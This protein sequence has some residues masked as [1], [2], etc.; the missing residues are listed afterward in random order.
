MKSKGFS[1]KRI[2]T[3]TVSSGVLAAMCTVGTA[4]LAQ[5]DDEADEIVV[6]GIRA[7]LADALDQKRNADILVE[8]IEAE[9]IGKLP[10]QNLA[11]VLENI[12]GVQ[13]NRDAGVGTGVQIRGT[14]SNRVEINGVST[15][16][17]GTNRTGISFEDLPASIISA[18]EV[19]KVPEAKTIEGSVGGTVNLRTI[20]PLGL[21]EPL[22]AFR[23]QGEFSDLSDSVNPR[24]SGT[25]GN[26]W[27]TSAGEFGLVV[28]GS[29]AEL[30]V[31]QFDPRFDRDRE[32]SPDPDRPSSEAF[33]FLRTQFLD[34]QITRNLFETLNFTGTAEW[35]P[36]DNLRFYFDATIND[37]QVQ[38][39]DARAFFSGIGSLGPVDA[40]TNTAFETVNL[41]T[42]DGPNGELDLGTVQAVLT[43][44]VGVGINPNN[45]IDTNLRTTSN[46]GSRVT[47]SRVFALGGEWSSDR[48]TVAA[49]GSLSTSDTVFPTLSVD[50]DF[51]NPNGPQPMVG[52]STDNGVP[53]EFDARDRT[54][55]FGIAQGL[56]ETP[57][58]EQ[59][60][61]PANYRL[62]QIVQGASTT[63]NSETAFRLDTNYDL[64][65]QVSFFTSVDAGY[66]YNLTEATNNVISDTLNLTSNGPATFF[67][68]TADLFA[69][70]VVAGPDNFDSA[71]GRA[72]F[73]RDYL[74]IDP[75]LA[76]SDPQ[77]VISGLNAAITQS[78]QIN[79]AS[80][81]LIGEPS[82]AQASFFDIDESTHALYFQANYDSVL[83]SLPV[84]GNVGLRW[85]STTQTTIGNNVVDGVAEP[86]ES[87]S[88]Y[89]AFLPRWSL[90]AEPKEDLLIR[91]GISRDLRRPNFDFLS[92]SVTFGTN[93]AATVDTG[94]PQ[95]EPE[96]V[97][98]YDISA[99]YYFA[100]TGILSLGFF[101]KRRTNLF[102]FV[103]DN[104][105]STISA[106]GQEERDITPPCEAGGIFNPN[107]NR[108]VF[109]SIEGEGICVPLLTRINADGVATQTGIEFQVQYDLAGFE[110]R[111]GWASGFGF[112][113]NFTYQDDGGSVD[114]FLD[115]SG[116]ANALNNVLGRTDTD[117]LT[118]TL[119]DDPVFQR[120]SLL[121]L[122]NLAYNATV[123]YDKYGVNFRARYTWRSDFLSDENPVSFD[124]PRVVDDRGQLNASLTYAINDNITVGIEGINLLREDRTEFCV[125]DEALLCEQGLTDRRITAG[126]SFRF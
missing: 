107:A 73:V 86:T 10:D 56:P 92:T 27:D 47:D 93:A 18:V 52:V 112:I 62:R 108:N 89:S 33:P 109:S 80:T 25:V 30:N 2:L 97:W 121:N 35:K 117:N 91:A 113:G 64:T 116:D 20:R 60:L 16:S 101:H 6:K 87:E 104:P 66:R 90:V 41:G 49:E 71:D 98:S 83:G 39:Q 21:S 126:V 115:G 9:D 28:S 68:P 13:I 102:T 99:E 14:D 4:A 44:V 88:S 19:I 34:Q 54:L 84:R 114:T 111:I 124:L 82:V 3:A 96:T 53:A 95:L 123:F 51:I 63:D 38:G 103:V 77:A 59:L 118:A 8:V 55:Q 67:R 94:N 24:F 43:G 42:L 120:V 45:T 32:L 1:A 78:N 17:N 37:Q 12:T 26:R 70:L 125:N 65:D 22:A 58:P 23:A 36:A 7:S 48:L 110:D 61:D 50:L 69:D 31:T 11:E 5:D 85:V 100:E 106:T 79:G 81:P 76:F 122:S 119:D 46:T 29:Y 40:T 72:L 75:D 105:A 57:T 15:V 74:L